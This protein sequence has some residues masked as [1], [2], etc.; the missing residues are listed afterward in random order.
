[1]TPIL[2][3]AESWA[4]AGWVM[5]SARAAEAARSA[6]RRTGER[7]AAVSYGAILSSLNRDGLDRAQA[8]SLGVDAAPWR[9]AAVFA[10]LMQA[11][12][13]PPDRGAKPPPAPCLPTR[14]RE[15]DQERLVDAR[16]R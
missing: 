1:M 8:Q 3:G 2:I 15:L 16:A 5:A 12:F 4:Q 14:S 11:D 10:L 13:S 7:V 9:K 6:P